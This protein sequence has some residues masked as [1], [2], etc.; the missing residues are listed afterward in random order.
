MCAIHAEEV[1]M[2]DDFIFSREQFEQ[3]INAIIAVYG[4]DRSAT[5]TMPDDTVARMQ[6]ITAELREQIYP[7]LRMNIVEELLNNGV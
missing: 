7:L 3:T 2:V 4:K 1:I 6:A 5:Y